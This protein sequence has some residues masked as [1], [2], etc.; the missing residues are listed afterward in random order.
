[1]VKAVR[2]AIGVMENSEAAIHAAARRLVGELLAGNRIS[3][4]RIIS[5][6][7][8]LTRDLDRGNPATGV[9][10]LG[11]SATPLLCLQEAEV[12]GAAPRIIRVQVTC[13]APRRAR[14]R[15]VYL[16]GAE[17][18]RADLRPDPRRSDPRRPDVGGSRSP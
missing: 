9:R 12:Q 8:T 13:H 1:M 17:R 2:G 3:E 16:D 7:F 18:L 11:F 15:A 6:I 5:I 10:T 4:R 14:L